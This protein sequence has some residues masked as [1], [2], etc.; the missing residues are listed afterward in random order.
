MLFVVLL[1]YKWLPKKKENRKEKL[2][3]F[4][5]VV[6]LQSPQ[7]TFIYICVFV[8]AQLHACTAMLQGYANIVGRMRE[9]LELKHGVV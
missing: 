1:F 3:P 7:K 6:L 4:I 5:G 8:L 2:P 9:R